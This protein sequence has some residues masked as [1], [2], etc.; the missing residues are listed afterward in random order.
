MMRI[1][2][3]RQPKVRRLTS[4]ACIHF[5]VDFHVQT[6]PTFSSRDI[7][8][9]YI[10]QL[11]PPTENA[12]L[13][14]TASA[15]SNSISTAPSIP[16]SS[17]PLDPSGPHGNAW[18]KWGPDDQLG[19]LNYLTDDIVAAAARENLRIGKRVSLK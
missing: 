2:N 8:F 13:T 7:T 4:L 10:P 14:T 1:Y 6:P 18:G 3:Q 19:T 5:S 17:L 15:M 16:F 9:D 11:D 12:K